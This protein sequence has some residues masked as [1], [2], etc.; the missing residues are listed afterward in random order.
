[1]K[2]LQEVYFAGVTTYSGAYFGQGTGPIFMDFVTCD[3][4]ELRLIDCRYSSADSSDTH[5][6]DVGVRCELCQ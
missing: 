6:E 4:S 2:L 1:M 3:G 5:A